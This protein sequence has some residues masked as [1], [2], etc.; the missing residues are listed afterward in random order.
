ML[1]SAKQLLQLIGESIRSPSRDKRQEPRHGPQTQ[2]TRHTHTHHTDS[3]RPAVLHPGSC[4]SAGPHRPPNWIGKPPTIELH[5]HVSLP[6][7]SFLIDKPILA[8]TVLLLSSPPPAY[9]PPPPF[10]DPRH[11][12]R[13]YPVRILTLVL[14]TLSALPGR[15]LPVSACSSSHAFLLPCPCRPHRL[16]CSVSL[17]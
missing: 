12:S 15:R 11:F 14:F 9:H 5:Q 17:D 7:G 13:P 2:K 10:L 16:P 3:Q 8:A 6:P 4:C 1:H